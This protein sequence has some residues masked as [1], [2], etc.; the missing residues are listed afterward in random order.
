MKKKIIIL[1]V[2]LLGL[3]WIT[4]VSSMVTTPG[5]INDHIK[6][7]EKYESKGIFIEAVGEYEEALKYDENNPEI[8]LKLAECYLKLGQS[9][10]F[11]DICKNASETNQKD[12]KLINR[13][14]EYYMD[15]SQEETAVKY[16]KQFVTKYPDNKEAQSWFLK[17]KGSYT[18]LFCEYHNMMPIN[19]SSIVVCENEKYGIATS[20]GDTVIPPIYDEI[21]PFSQDVYALALRD[22]GDYVYLDIHGYVRKVVDKEYENLGMLYEGRTTAS[23]KGKYGLLNE[24]MKEV[25]EFKWDKITGIK[26]KMGAACKDGKWAIIDNDGEEKSKYIYKDVIVDENGYCS[27]QEVI[28][29]KQD[30]KYFLIDKKGK[31]IGDLEFDNA[32]A[33]ND[34]GYAAVCNDGKWG[35]I[36]SDGK[37]VIDYKHENAESFSYGYAS[38]CNNKKWDY[39]DRKGNQITDTGFA[40]PSPMSKNGTAV[41]KYLGRK[42]EG[43]QLIQ[44]NLYKE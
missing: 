24:G 39:I 29:V 34:E 17:L 23:K 8:S 3:A 22:N 21:H 42:D 19:N 43:G 6:R 12:S 35:Y 32:K 41:V 36:D 11:I 14:M 40:E 16:L 5:E 33:F 31:K 44:L 28:F 4:T 38:I 26:N 30:K 10:K 1:L 18:P 7:A 27:A 13:L 25:S 2:A 20:L 9:G 15:N 37:L